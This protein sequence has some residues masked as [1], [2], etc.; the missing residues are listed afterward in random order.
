MIMICFPSMSQSKIDIVKLNGPGDDYFGKPYKA[1]SLVVTGECVENDLF[2]RMSSHSGDSEIL[3]NV[4]YL[5]ASQTVILNENFPEGINV[6]DNYAFRHCRELEHIILPATTNR[7]GHHLFEDCPKLH[8]VVLPDSLVEIEQMALADCPTLRNIII[9]TS[10]KSFS[11]LNKSLFDKNKTRL[12]FVSPTSS[13][14]YVLLSSV[15]TIEYGAF[16]KCDKID[17]VKSSNVLKNIE[18][19]SFYGC[20]SLS[21]IELAKTLNKIGDFAFFK[22][23]SLK[24]ITLPKALNKFGK[25]A[26]SGCDGMEIVNVESGY[27]DNNFLFAGCYNLK[28]FVA[29]EVNAHFSSKDGVLFDKS[30]KTLLA[31][32]NAKGS[33]YKVPDSVEKIGVCAFYDC[34]NLKKISLPAQITAIERASFSNCKQLENIR[35]YAVNPPSVQ[36]SSFAMVD[37]RKCVLS[38]PSNSVES[39]KKHPIWGTFANIIGF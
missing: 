13:G 33:D 17:R 1:D 35:I 18:D 4:K 14:E 23:R 2:G 11:T 7:L 3:L 31:Y 16:Y 9:N 37:K 21:H 34:K 6:I 32:P 20:S 27:F 19:F 29:T 24:E 28:S 30:V 12:Y 22:C 10:N 26:F 38:V 39:Y 15:S 8:T 36:K 5:D 25:F